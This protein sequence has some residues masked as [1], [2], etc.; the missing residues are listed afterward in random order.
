MTS[1]MTLSSVS[2]I[3]CR[4][5][6]LWWN[7]K[8]SFFGAMLRLKYLCVCVVVISILFPPFFSF[9][10]KTN[11]QWSK[12]GNN[13]KF[14]VQLIVSQYIQAVL[15]IIVSGW[16]PNYKSYLAYCRLW[17]G[18]HICICHCRHLSC[19]K[20]MAKNE[21]QWKSQKNH[22]WLFKKRKGRFL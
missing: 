12:D 15:A 7:K 3:E 2:K 1:H 14:Q 10:L 4:A 5:A 17:P 21:S 6:S 19:P 11:K 22:L 8:H 20:I 13:K 16:M 9:L 18:R